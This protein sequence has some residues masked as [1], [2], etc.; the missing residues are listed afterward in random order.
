MAWLG[1]DRYHVEL[2]AETARLAAT[3]HDA[4][5]SQPVPTCPDWTLAQLTAHVGFGHRW[6]ATII[7]RRATGP[8]PHQEADDLLV[9][10][11]ADARSAWLLAG[12]RRLGD[13]VRELGPRTRVWT[14]AADQTAGFWLRKLTHAADLGLGP[15]GEW[16]V[17]RTPSGVVWEHGHG[18]ADVA[19]RGRALDLLLVLNRRAVPDGSRVEV[20][21]DERLFAHWLEHSAFA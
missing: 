15:A 21:G 7:E 5:P 18:R 14:W 17:R 19:V 11:G 20:L 12:A 10:E 4:D 6:A 9:P 16:L 13:V 2:D 1:D 8:V 3:L